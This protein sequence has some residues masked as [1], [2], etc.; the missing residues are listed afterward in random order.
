MA[1]T[2]VL[3]NELLIPIVGH[4]RDGKINHFDSAATKDLQTMRLVSFQVHDLPFRGL[5]WL[6]LTVALFHFAVLGDR[7]T[8][9]VRKHG[10]G[11]E[12]RA[13]GRRK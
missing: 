11:Y 1:N 6:A 2:C 7:Y 3:P 10:F 8:Y 12:A 9:A 5:A 4:L 13:Y